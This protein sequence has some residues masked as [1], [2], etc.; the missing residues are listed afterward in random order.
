VCVCV[1]VGK[2]GGERGRERERPRERKRE[3]ERLFLR[4]DRQVHLHT[5]VRFWGGLNSAPTLLPRATGG[6]VADRALDF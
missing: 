1:C 4:C 5:R 2:E 3:R 6:S